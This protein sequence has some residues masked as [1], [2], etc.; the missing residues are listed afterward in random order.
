M[1]LRSSDITPDYNPFEAG[2]QFLI[3]WDKGDCMGRDAFKK[4]KEI[5]VRQNWSAWFWK[6]RCMSLAARR[7]L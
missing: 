7:Y 1:G 6:N 4:I 5:G 2:L 3:D